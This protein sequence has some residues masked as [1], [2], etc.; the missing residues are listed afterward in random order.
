MKLGHHAG[1]KC[2]PVINIYLGM[3]VG[4]CLPCDEECQSRILKTFISSSF[5]AMSNNRSFFP[6]EMI[7]ISFTSPSRINPVSPGALF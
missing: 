3:N 1:I 7:L 4:T 2:C 6:V 5:T